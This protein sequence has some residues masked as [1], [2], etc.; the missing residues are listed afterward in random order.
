MKI[1]I[2]WERL[3]AALGEELDGGR[4]RC[5]MRLQRNQKLRKNQ[6]NL[7]KQQAIKTKLGFDK[8]CF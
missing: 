6:L 1:K 3:K 8:S 4:E 7:E 2:N 5:N